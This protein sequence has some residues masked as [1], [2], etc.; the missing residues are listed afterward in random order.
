MYIHRVCR[1][2][3][4]PDNHFCRALVYFVRCT[5]TGDLNYRTQVNLQGG[6]PAKLKAGMKKYCPRLR[7]HTLHKVK[8]K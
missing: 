4:M 1:H 2:Y 3:T 7:R 5:E 6:V 8:R